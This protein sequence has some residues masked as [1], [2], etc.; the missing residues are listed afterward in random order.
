MFEQL[1][2]DI[3]IVFDRDPAARNTLEI[4]TTYPGFHAILFHRLNN[5]LW[6]SN[7]KFLAR[8]FSYFSRWLTGIEIHPGAIIGKRFFIDHGM[9]IVIG[10]T[11]VIG[12]DCTLYHGVTLGV[13]RAGAASLDLAYVAAGKL[14][15]FFEI[16]LKPWDLAAG[17]LMI[18]EAGGLVTDFENN[19]GYFETG[20]I[21]C[22]NPRMHRILLDKITPHAKKVLNED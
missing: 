8:F 15:G 19:H 17:V 6:R 14:D 3:N 13:R 4:V 20:N 22:G 1:K 5:W 21:I 10:E 16:G 18:Q 12:D 7:L 9:G 2:E 11:A